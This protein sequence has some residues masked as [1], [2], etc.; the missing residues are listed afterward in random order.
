MNRIIISFRNSSPQI[1]PRPSI[2]LRIATAHPSPD[3]TINASAGQLTAQDPHSIQV[4][5]LYNPSH[6]VFQIKNSVRIHHQAHAANH[7]FF[8]VRF[9]CNTPLNIDQLSHDLDII[10][11]HL[12]HKKMSGIIGSRQ[13]GKSSLLFLIIAH[14]IVET[15]LTSI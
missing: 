11:R 3:S 4:S 2:S 10:L 15:A 7:A 8:S 1:H 9:Q 14:L 13:V 5:R 6:F 12:D